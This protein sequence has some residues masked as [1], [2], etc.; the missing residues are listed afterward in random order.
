MRV[1]TGTARGRKLLTLPGGDAVRPTSGRVKEAMF[2]ILQFGL[3]G[4][5]VL[6]LFAGCGQLGIEALSR[7]AAKATFVDSDEAAVSVVVQNLRAAALLDRASVLCRDGISFLEI[8][9]EEFDVILLDP[10]YK[11]QL[12]QRALPGAVRRCAPDGILLCETHISEELPETVGG[13]RLFRTYKYGKTK[14]TTYR[15]N[16]EEAPR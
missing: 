8:A 16:D 15:K 12:V 7:G 13:F 2:S 3:A 14:L 5:R 10:P 11:K 9:G 4:A 6:D 1:I